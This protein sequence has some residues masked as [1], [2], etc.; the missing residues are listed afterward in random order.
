[1]LSTA[2]ADGLDGKQEVVSA[3][4]VYRRLQE[5]EAA[6]SIEESKQKEEKIAE[7][8][9][10]EEKRRAEEAQ[11]QEKRR[12]EEARAQEKQRAEEAQAQEKRK[13]HD[14]VRQVPAQDKRSRRDVSG[15]LNSTQ[16]RR[17][18]IQDVSH[19]TVGS[20]TYAFCVSNYL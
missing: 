16:Q 3:R 8:A 12:A 11:A 2:S 5:Q 14:T 1:M 4:E 18:A 6:R 20:I 10:I 9:R 13:T 19:I 15:L 7:E 17:A